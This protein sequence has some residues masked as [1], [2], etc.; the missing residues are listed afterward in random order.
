M[1][2]IQYLVVPV[3][4]NIWN[5]EA[6]VNQLKKRYESPSVATDAAYALSKQYNDN[7]FIVAPIQVTIS[8]TMKVA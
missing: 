6:V 8:A 7:E 2:K 5:D 1:K 3:N 4:P